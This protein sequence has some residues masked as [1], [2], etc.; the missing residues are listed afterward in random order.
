MDIDRCNSIFELSTAFNFTYAIFSR[1]NGDN[2]LIN[3]ESNKTSFVEVID[4]YFLKPFSIFFNDIQALEDDVLLLNESSSSIIKV[5]N[6]NK[7]KLQRFK[8]INSRINGLS[9]QIAQWKQDVLT[10]KNNTKAEINNRFPYISFLSA[11]FCISVLGIA[12]SE[13]EYKHFT[14]FV[15]D[16]FV[17]ALIA[18]SIIWGRESTYSQIIVSYLVGLSLL[19]LIHFGIK[20]NYENFGE[21]SCYWIT[22]LNNDS[23]GKSFFIMCNLAL[24]FWHF[25]W[26]YFKLDIKIKRLKKLKQDTL[27]NYKKTYGGYKKEWD[28]LTK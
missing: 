3:E 13:A 10:E 20:L 24:P 14:L 17:I 8:D 15:L 9:I 18:I 11:L 12:A 6:K 23:F 16:I 28:E 4:N 2:S 21:T 25:V 26:Y 1:I 5:E 19:I 7:A 27:D 22:L